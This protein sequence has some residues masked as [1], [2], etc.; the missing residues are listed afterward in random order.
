MAATYNTLTL[1]LQTPAALPVSDIVGSQLDC[2]LLP[3][4][5]YQGI[6]DSVK[7][8]GT[9]SQPSFMLVEADGQLSAL[10]PIATVTYASATGAQTVVVAGVSQAFTAGAN[11]AATVLV[12]IAAINANPALF[13]LVTASV[14]PAAPTVL[15]LQARWPGIA[16]NANTLS[17]TT[18]GGTA[19]VSAAT[20]GGSAVSPARAGVAISQVNQL[21]IGPPSTP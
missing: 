18:A 12:A 6:L 3:Q 11:D 2:V 21:G 17:A 16:Q 1:Q 8:I 5:T 19:T 10:A 9:F 15:V 7:S 13:L 20:L 4:V 14:Q